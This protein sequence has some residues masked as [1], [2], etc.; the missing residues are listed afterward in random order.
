ML[1]YS[2]AEEL[3]AN[4]SREKISIGELALRREIEGRDVYFVVNPSD[5]AFDGGVS[6]AATG[7]PEL[8][9]AVDGSTRPLP[10]AAPSASRPAEKG[11]VRVLRV[12]GESRKGR[13][14]VEVETLLRP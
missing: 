12:A 5:T 4:C 10:V 2:T 3:L 1:S 14:F 8:W 11:R 6:F 7:A 9:D 13:L